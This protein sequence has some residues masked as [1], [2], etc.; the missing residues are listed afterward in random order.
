MHTTIHECAGQLKEDLQAIIPSEAL[1]Q[2][3]T[4][5]QATEHACE[6]AVQA[7]WNIADILFEIVK[8]TTGWSVLNVERAPS[9]ALGL[10]KTNPI[11]RESHLVN[12]RHSINYL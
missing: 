6:H 10:S 2:K 7:A 12:L 8:P 11:N 1:S 3:Y 9:I 5:I 4:E